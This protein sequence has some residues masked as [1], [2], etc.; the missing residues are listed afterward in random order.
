M[1]ETQTE[2]TANFAAAD[3]HVFGMLLSE[4]VDALK[5]R[6]VLR[7]ED[8]AGALLRA[9]YRAEM[10]DS[11][12]EEEG[13]INGHHV[14]AARLTIDAWSNR[15]D[16]EP[17]LDELRAEHTDWLATDQK[18]TPA[19]DAERIVRDYPDCEKQK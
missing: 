2:R 17:A 1:K 6:G 14:A 15:L 18:G 4:I 3:A 9:E 8:I 19:I 7:A 12:G 16:L 13:D 11:F 10:A 5:A